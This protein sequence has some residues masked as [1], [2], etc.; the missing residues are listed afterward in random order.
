M[1][2]TPGVRV[3]PRHRAV[4]HHAER[5]AVRNGDQGDPGRGHRSRQRDEGRLGEAATNRLRQQRALAADRE[6]DHDATTAHEVDTGREF[7]HERIARVVRLS[8]QPADAGRL[9]QACLPDG[10][11][12]GIEPAA[13]EAVEERAGGTGMFGVP[14]LPVPV[15]LFGD[16]LGGAQPLAVGGERGR[17]GGGAPGTR[18]KQPDGHL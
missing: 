13:G 2:G 3:G 5:H 15:D 16:Q 9:D 7:V 4:G 8:E 1:A 10:G 17:G 11:V 18:A 12:A 6:L 14:R